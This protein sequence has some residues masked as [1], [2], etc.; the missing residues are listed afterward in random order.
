MSALIITLG[1]WLKSAHNSPIT[2]QTPQIGGPQSSPSKYGQT[3]AE[4]AKICIEMYWE[5]VNGISI[6]ANLN[7]LTLS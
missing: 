3:V 1:I 2:P 7:L 4:I 5:V 6:R